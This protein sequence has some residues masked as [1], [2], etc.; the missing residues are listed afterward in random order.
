M[1]HTPPP[2]PF[3]DY[4]STKAGRARLDEIRANYERVANNPDASTTDRIAAAF[5]FRQAYSIDGGLEGL[6]GSASTYHLGELC[7]RM[8]QVVDTLR[9]DCIHFTGLPKHRRARKTLGFLSN[10]YGERYYVGLRGLHHALLDAGASKTTLREFMATRQ[11]FDE[12]FTKMMYAAHVVNERGENLPAVRQCIRMFI[13]ELMALCEWQSRTRERITCA[14]NRSHLNSA[15]TE[16]GKS[17]RPSGR[18]TR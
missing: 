9:P 17:H 11:A 5:D 2:S 7:G 8:P 10:M 1:H 4:F 13:D 6:T 3:V 14:L 18:K 15:L 16:L 12:E